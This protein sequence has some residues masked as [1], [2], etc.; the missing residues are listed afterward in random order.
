MSQDAY[1]G[2]AQFTVSLDGQ[3]V[4][5]VLT[6]SSLHGSGTSDTVNVLANLSPGQHT[7]AVNFLNDAYNG[8]ADTDRNL[9][10]DSATYDGVAVSRAAQTLLSSGP[11]SFGVADTSFVPGGSLIVPAGVTAI[12]QG[13]ELAGQGVSLDG[14]FGSPASLTLNGATIGSLAVVDADL[15]NGSSAYFGHLDVYGQSAI[16]GNT[17]IGGSRPL[18]PGFVDA[19]VHGADGVLT[20]QG[21]FLGGSSTLTIT[22]DQGATVENDGNI[23]IQG[24]A[25]TGAVNIQTNL[26]G[27]G[28]IGG[29]QDVAGDPASVR[30]GGAVGAGQTISL[31]QTNLELNQPMMFAGTLSGFNSNGIQ[32]ITRPGLTLDHETVTG[33]SFQQSSAGLGDL[34]VFTQD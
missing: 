19:Y 28:T 26:Q 21:A 32:G 1:Q 3:Q 7:V 27:T 6:A 18:A 15:T 25:T 11:A 16:T 31:S 24:G 34:S 13:N 10:I 12:V 2:N 23:G 30:L 4:G 14:T 9:Y 20:L 29:G 8:T 33:A 5:D 22:G 17:T